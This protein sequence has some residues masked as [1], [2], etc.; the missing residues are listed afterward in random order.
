MS[1]L[2]EQKQ[3]DDD[4]AQSIISSVSHMAG[5]VDNVQHQ[6][7]FNLWQ[8]L[9]MNFAISCA[10]L[11]I[12]A[13]LAFIIGLGGSPFYIW[14]YLF[15]VIFQLITCVAI[16]EIASAMPHASGMFIV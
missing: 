3:K 7:R 10:P 16:A 9:G 12:G 8:I 15:A 13:Y 2:I 4:P 6:V 1:D 5:E 14:G 11:S